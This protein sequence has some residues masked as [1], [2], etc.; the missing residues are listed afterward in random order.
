MS[1]PY[2]AREAR[3]RFFPRLWHVKSTEIGDVGSPA[4]VRASPKAPTKS[5]EIAR[6]VYEIPTSSYRSGAHAGRRQVSH[7]CVGSRT[8]APAAVPASVDTDST[9]T[10]IKRGQGLTCHISHQHTPQAMNAG[11]ERARR[12]GPRQRQTPGRWRRGSPVGQARG[13]VEGT[14]HL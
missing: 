1:R 8:L 5:W 2:G 3:H 14:A 10:K 9:I 11:P 6:L 12:R 7:F 4:A 13:A